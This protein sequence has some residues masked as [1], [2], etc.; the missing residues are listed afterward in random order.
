LLGLVTTP[1]SE[2]G[3]LLSALCAMKP[4]F[5]P[6]C[7]QLVSLD[8]ARLAGADLH[9]LE[10]FGWM[11]RID[12]SGADLRGALLRH[13]PL[14]C[15]VLEGAQLAGATLLGITGRRLAADG[16]SDAGMKAEHCDFHGSDF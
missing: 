13:N 15:A 9:D 3:T 8:G 11:Q 7:R 6:P 4:G 2:Q 10:L 14:D 12:L 5:R 1:A 16:V